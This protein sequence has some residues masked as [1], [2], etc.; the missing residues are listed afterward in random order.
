[1]PA[2]GARLS[3]PPRAGRASRFSRPSRFSRLSRFSRSRRERRPRSRRPRRPSVSS[4]SGSSMFRTVSTT[5]VSGSGVDSLRSEAGSGRS[6]VT[7]AGSTAPWLTARRRRE[8]RSPSAAGISTAGLSARGTSGCAGT[9][10]VSDDEAGVSSR[11]AASCVV[12]ALASLLRSSISWGLRSWEMPLRPRDAARAFS[13]GSFI[14]D[15]DAV[16]I[17]A[18]FSLLTKWSL[19]ECAQVGR[20]ELLKHTKKLDGRRC[21]MRAHRND[22]S[23]AF[24]SDLKKI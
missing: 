9:A 14:A 11:G 21:A 12:G 24:D 15:S 2:I 18:G 23:R 16:V 4:P 6:R 13:S 19:L 5:V 22:R 3:S 8:R 17:S 20:G 7:C 10:R 1:M